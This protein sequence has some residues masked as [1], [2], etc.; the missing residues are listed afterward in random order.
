MVSFFFLVEWVVVSIF[1]KYVVE[2]SDWLQ[3]QFLEKKMVE[4]LR[5]AGAMGYCWCIFKSKTLSASSSC[6]TC[7]RL[8]VPCVNM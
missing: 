6:A 3:I 7:Q 8:V 1:L 5:I 4:G 2:K